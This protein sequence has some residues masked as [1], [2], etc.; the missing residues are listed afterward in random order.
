MISEIFPLRVRGRG[1]SLAVLINFAANALVTFAFS[2]LEVNILLIVPFYNVL[3]DNNT[4]WF[5]FEKFL[6]LF[7]IEHY[8]MGRPC[9]ELGYCSSYLE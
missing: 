1:L 9:W 8:L 7:L 4:P 3:I 5:E 2:P 6:L